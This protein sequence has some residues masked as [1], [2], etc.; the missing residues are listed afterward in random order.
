MRAPGFWWRPPGLAAACLAPAALAYGTV[1]ARR[2]SRAGA[3]AALPVVCIGNVTVGGSGKTPTAIAV[4]AMLREAGW[5]PAF[6][7]RGYGG[8]LAGPVAVDPERHGATDVGDEALLLARHA[9]T[10]VSRDR[11]VGAAAAGAL[12]AD[13]VVMDDG[14]QNPSL[15]KTLSLAVF[16]GAV[17]IGNG[18][19]LPA[20][21]LRAP[22]PAQW[23]RMDAVVIVGSGAAGD[24]VAREAAGHGLP[25][26][27]AAL[28]P[29]PEAASALA[30]RRVLAFAGIGRPEKFVQTCREA[31]LD[32]VAI[33][34]YPD[35]HPFTP[36]E[37]SGLLDEAERDG[38]V[39]VTT[40]KDEV[41]LFSLAPR[42][43][44]LALVRTLP[45]TLDVAEP[46]VVRSFL[47][48]RLPATRVSRPCGAAADPSA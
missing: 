6:L 27:R 25:V 33:R 39:P 2:M 46:D 3:A 1:A 45:V 17:G 23:P 15:A 21:P 24:A 10:I 40:E 30:G 36:A 4:A 38:L 8:R 28:V 5:G 12:G 7:L 35:H 29:H 11:P 14:L 48:E 16:D 41:R 26:F 37:L 43:P 22:L 9:P 47:A 13:V 20:G 44:R 18:R 31:G 42:D 32:V 34:S 19:V